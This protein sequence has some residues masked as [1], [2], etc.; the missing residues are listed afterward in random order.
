MGDLAWHVDT[1]VLNAIMMKSYP[2]R[3]SAV[4][5]FPDFDAD[6]VTLDTVR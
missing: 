3:C 1:I 2:T 4:Q 6:T 5:V